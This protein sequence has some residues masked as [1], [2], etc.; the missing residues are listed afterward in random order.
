MPSGGGGGG[1]RIGPIQGGGVPHPQVRG[2]RGVALQG[3]G[4]C[5][6]LSDDGFG[7]CRQVTMGNT[8]QWNFTGAICKKKSYDCA[9]MR[10]GIYL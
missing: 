10:T 9:Y 6:G 3:T 1:R 8:C 2:G 5:K 7:A 4:E